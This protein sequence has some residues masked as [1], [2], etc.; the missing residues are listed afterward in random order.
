V[1]RR[2]K[3][4]VRVHRH[5]GIYRVWHLLSLHLDERNIVAMPNNHSD[6]RLAHNSV[7][8]ILSLVALPAAIAIWF[9]AVSSQVHEPY[10]V[11]RAR[12]CF[13]L[14]KLIIF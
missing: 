12:I 1:G 10:L 14:N 6:D 3:L 11:G 7:P 2:S 8:L 9:N 13:L 5:L 4:H